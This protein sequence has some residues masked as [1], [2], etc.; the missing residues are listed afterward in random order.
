MRLHHHACRTDIY[1]VRLCVVRAE[2]LQGVPTYSTGKIARIMYT[3]KDVLIPPMDGHS[4]KDVYSKVTFEN[5]G[6]SML[7]N[8]PSR[9]L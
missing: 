5:A 6:A 1:S 9:N 3:Q 4:P 7:Q 2:D 8:T